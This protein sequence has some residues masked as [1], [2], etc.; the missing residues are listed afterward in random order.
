[1]WKLQKMFN[2]TIVKVSEIFPLTSMDKRVLNRLKSYLPSRRNLKVQKQSI[3]R[4]I[5]VLFNN[6]QN[7]D[8]IAK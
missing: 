2:P 3:L 7:N 6:F 8:I 4:G 5:P 1:M